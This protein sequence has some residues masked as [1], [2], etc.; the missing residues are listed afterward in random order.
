MKANSKNSLIDR[1][2]QKDQSAQNEL[3]KKFNARLLVYF[4]LRIKGEESYQDL[5]QEV[6]VS[7]F[8]GVEKDKI[9]GDDFIAPYIYGIARRVMFNYFYNKKRNA[10]LQE[11]GEANFEL[12]YDF[13]EAERL[14]NEDLNEMIGQ[15]MKKLPEVDK[16]ILKEFYLKENTVYEVAALLGKTPHYISVRKER[17]LKKVKNEILNKKFI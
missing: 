7:F 17:A 1:L 11:K 16:I 12:S 8:V 9:P 10:K 5:V 4:R 15:A 3:I 13:E 14:E 2:K 6:L